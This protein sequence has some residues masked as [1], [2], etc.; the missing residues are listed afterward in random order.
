MITMQNL[1]DIDFR[2]MTFNEISSSMEYTASQESIKNICR[3]SGAVGQAVQEILSTVLFVL[4]DT[5][6]L[7]CGY[8][9][10]STLVAIII[11]D[12]VLAFNIL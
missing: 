12:A 10:F 11:C 1:V 9:A 8:N 5:R 3:G 4:P 7:L 6:G 2:K